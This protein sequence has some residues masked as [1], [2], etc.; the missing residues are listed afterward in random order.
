MFR[1]EQQNASYS[2]NI[3]SHGRV[4]LSDQSNL[5]RICA[6]AELRPRASTQLPGQ[7]VFHGF[8]DTSISNHLPLPRAL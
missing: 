3:L 6:S 5:E 1:T 7:C 2:D 4:P 8:M